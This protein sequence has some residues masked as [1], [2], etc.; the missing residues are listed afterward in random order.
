MKSL[1]ESRRSNL[2]EEDN[3][4]IVF[5]EGFVE[6]NELIQAKMNGNAL[7]ISYQYIV[8]LIY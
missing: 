7:L 6:P 1:I 4:L 3:R 5:Q 2:I 8:L